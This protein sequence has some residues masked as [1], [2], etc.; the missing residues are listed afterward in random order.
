MAPWHPDNQDEGIEQTAEPMSASETR[1]CR[2][3]QDLLDDG[4]TYFNFDFDLKDHELHHLHQLNQIITLPPGDGIEVPVEGQYRSMIPELHL[5]L[6]FNKL[7]YL[8]PTLFQ[9]QHLTTLTLRNNFIESVPPQ[10]KDLT[11]LHTLDLCNNSIRELPCELLAICAMQGPGRLTR[12]ELAHNPLY[13][14]KD[15]LCRLIKA[16]WK[17]V[18]ERTPRYEPASSQR[19]EPAYS[20]HKRVRGSRRLIQ[21]FVDMDWSAFEGH[22]LYTPPPMKTHTINPDIFEDKLFLVCRTAPSY[23]DHTGRLLRN[24][25]ALPNHKDMDDSFDESWGDMVRSFVTNILP[26]A[27]S[28]HET[29]FDRPSSSQV[30]SLGTISLIKAYKTEPDRVREELHDYFGG[31][32]P[33]GIEASLD[34]AEENEVTIFKPL[35]SCHCCGKQ[36]I[37]PRAEWVEGWWFQEQLVPIKVAVCSWGCVP[38]VIADKPEPLKYKDLRQPSEP[39]S[40]GSEQPPEP[41]PRD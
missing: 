29:W 28:V 38:D 31:G 6:S 16:A 10:I 17:T 32:I 24:S 4:T 26:T 37:V 8:S 19:Y 3:I 35:R 30:L 34:R 41:L 21:K 40:E 20:Q 7:R 12:L 5:N 9:L 18:T 33:G 2:A 1:L 25:H 23:Y 13:V 11:N 22:H 14:F 15:G 36:Y 27:E 39:T